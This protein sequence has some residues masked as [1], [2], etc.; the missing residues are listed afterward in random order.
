MITS[1]EM[2][3]GSVGGAGLRYRGAGLPA[4]RWWS[5]PL[6]ALW[7]AV[8]LLGQVGPAHSAQAQV[9]G[10][11][12]TSP[13]LPYT[14]TW[15]DTWFV[16]GEEST[17]VDALTLTNGLTYC[18]VIGIPGPA[19]T[20][21]NALAGL[22]SE[23]RSEPAISDFAPLR[24]ENDEVIRESGI[25]FVLAAFSYTFT[26]VDGSAYSLARYIHVQSIVPGESVV[27]FV[28]EM[29]A[30][31]FESERPH[32]EEL[33]SGV[34]VGPG[35]VPAPTSGEPAPVFVSGSWRIAV[36]TT[37]VSRAFADLGLKEKADK[38]W[39]VVILDVTNW[40]DED[41]E[42][43]ARDFTI[44]GSDGE[45]IGKIA[46]SSMSRIAD[47]L[48]V[49]PFADD[50]TMRVPAGETMRIAL[51][52]VI[53]KRSASVRL[54]QDGTA[55]PLVTTIGSEL[56]VDALPGPAR[57][58]EVV[59]AEIV[60]ASDGRTMRVRPDGEIAA[61][62]IRL[63]GVEPPAEGSCH[64][65]TA[66]LF[67]EELT[68]AE[69]LVEEDPAITSVSGSARY[70]WL[71][72]DDG[73]RTLLNHALIAEGMVMALPMPSDA[74]FGV[75]LAETE[76]AAEQAE[77]GLWAGCPESDSRGDAERS[78]TPFATPTDN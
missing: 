45:T 77:T 54:V 22:L 51:A 55:L 53:P 10:N 68:G 20:P 69:I 75:W 29:L 62:R 3:S 49:A 9:S 4:G 70:I 16:V 66:E 52:F 6:I 72:N 25:G 59:R 58:A 27:V 71:V 78:D 13:Q 2:G 39:M 33:L 17:E 35:P 63:L 30:S 74:R 41:A 50:L 1:F 44:E 7:I 31:S 47:G 34:V 28:C 57:P 24:D 65:D 26:D 12:Y 14:V 43:S 73:T 42:L 46:R 61:T 19:F 23:L 56:E 64:E 60:S 5:R 76:R 11:T 38:E 21:E 37:A 67:L 36:A 40:S 8:L 32:F 48:G 18:F 15:D